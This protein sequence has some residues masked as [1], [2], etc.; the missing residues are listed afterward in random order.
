VHNLFAALLFSTTCLSAQILVSMDIMTSVGTAPQ[1]GRGTGA[2]TVN[3][4][5]TGLGPN[6]VPFTLVR[7]AFP[8][9][10]I[11]S[12]TQGTLILTTR[13][14]QSLPARVSKYLGYSGAVSGI[15]VTIEEKLKRSPS[16]LGPGITAAGLAIPGIQAMVIKKIPNYTITNAP[17]DI[18][19]L[20]PNQGAEYTWLCARG[21]L[22][23]PT[24]GQRRVDP[25]PTP[26][27]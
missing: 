25:I 8:E 19:T 1:V 21:T 7:Q 14:E 22:P 18:I 26:S 3:I 5:V 10:R 2:Y 17:P 12:I 13:V 4:H 16:W 23:A 27:H 24:I 15:G 9:I 11:Y 6:P 20:A